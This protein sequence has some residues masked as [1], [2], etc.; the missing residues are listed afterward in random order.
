MNIFLIVLDIV[1]IGMAGYY[2]YWQSKVEYQANYSYPQLFWGLILLM[3]FVT[4]RIVNWPYV[5]FIAI[6]VLLSVMAGIGGLGRDRLIATGIFQ[7]VIPYTSLAEINLTPLT[8]PN[9]KQ[10]VIA[11]FSVSPRRYVRLTFKSNLEGMLAALKEVIPDTV[12]IKVQ[13]VQ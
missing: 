2:V 5:I 6:F 3:W 13:E 9:G 10:V 1:L 4:S 7:R 11:T 8:M 12:A